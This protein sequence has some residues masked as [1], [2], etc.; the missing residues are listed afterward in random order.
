MIVGLALIV[1]GVA[2]Q[3]VQPQSVLWSDEQAAALAEAAAALH[4]EE[5]GHSGGHD[6]AGDPHQSAADELGATAAQARFDEL[7]NQLK[8]ARQLRDT[9][10]LRLIQYGFGLTALCG[11]GYLAVRHGG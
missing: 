6:H 11:L 10:G 9:L 2:W 7:N 8:S 1:A 3:T 4:A 5:H